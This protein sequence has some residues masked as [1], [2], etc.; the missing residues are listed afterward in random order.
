MK[1]FK[2]ALKVDANFFAK[3]KIMSERLLHTWRLVHVLF[4]QMAMVGEHL[5]GIEPRSISNTGSP[6]HQQASSDRDLAAGL[7]IFK[8]IANLLD[9]TFIRNMFIFCAQL[10]RINENWSEISDLLRREL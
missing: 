5:Q 9:D 8:G 10:G 2:E 7:R 4:K 1:S 6:N 3:D